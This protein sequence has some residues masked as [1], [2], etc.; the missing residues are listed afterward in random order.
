MA[1]SLR[2]LYSRVIQSF[3]ALFLT[4]ARAFA[5]RGSPLHVLAAT[6]YWVLH[7]VVFANTSWDRFQLDIFVE[8]KEKRT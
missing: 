5:L 8:A 3:L 2:A 4:L 6:D 1:T 7:W